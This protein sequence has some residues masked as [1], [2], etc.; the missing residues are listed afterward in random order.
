MG[1]AQGTQEGKQNTGN[2][3]EQEVVSDS[4]TQE[5]TTT[6]LNRKSTN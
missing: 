2:T 1:G 6:K 3:G 4:K 5:D